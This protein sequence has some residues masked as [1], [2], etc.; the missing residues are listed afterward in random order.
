MGIRLTLYSR[1]YCHLCGEMIAV[2]R[3]L[4]AGLP[5]EL[6]IVDVDSAP[7]LERRYGEKV[8]VLVHHGEEIC[9]YR[10][11]PAVFTEYLAKIC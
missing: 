2:L 4:Q 1:E 11:E 8:P 3:R 7:E 10:L 5:F 9:H 6:E